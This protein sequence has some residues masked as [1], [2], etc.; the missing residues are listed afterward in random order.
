[1]P[2]P[3]AVS[4]AFL[5]YRSVA[6]DYRQARLARLRAAQNADGGWG[7]F[8]K[9][10]SWLEP[11]CYA[12]LALHKDAGSEQAWRRGWELVRSW[13]LADGSWKPSANVATSG[14]AT[15]LCVTLH[16]VQGLFDQPFHR[17][18]EWMLQTRGS[19]GSLLERAIN[20]VRP[21]P[22]EYDRRFK[23]WP[24]HPETTS[25]VEPTAHSVLALKKSA[26]KLP[27]AA[28]RIEEAERMMADRRAKDGGWNY[29][30]RRVLNVDLP[31]FPE[32]T[33][34]A[35]L[36]L[37]GS[38]VVD[39]EPALLLAGRHLRQTRSPLA[40]AWLGISLR[41]FGRDLPPPAASEPGDDL[42]LAA[43]EALAYP[44][45]GHQWLKAG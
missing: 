23:G 13:Q 9:R 22:V 24:W 8:P 45:G 28:A 14:W 18:A 16:C 43:L 2:A 44:Q 25:W 33:A 6:S 40:K 27:G 38:K 12:L 10:H 19:E 32:T 30:N 7:Y 29:G 1:M 26:A 42:L 37:Q 35:L 15:A 21:L 4:K 39:L 20:L 17:G 41:N 31:S 5:R 3:R 11:T 36:G 34:I